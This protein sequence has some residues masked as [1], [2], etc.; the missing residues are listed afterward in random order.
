V[1]EPT[2]WDRVDERVLRWVATLPPSLAME[3]HLF[4]VARPEPFEPIPGLTSRD[5]H[6]SLRR[7]VSAGL[8]DGSEGPPLQ[9]VD[10]SKL[11]VTASG[12]IVLG[13]WPD[14]DRVATATS[15]HR[16]LRALAEDAPE[17]ERS[18]LVRAAGVVSRT[19]DEIVR[20]A[21]ADIAGTIVR[22]AVDP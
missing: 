1:A 21:A 17:E 22:E 15:L 19:A 11:R 3:I 2:L 10:W 20:G 12:W 13:E 18:A 14:L 7:L 6:A 4:E 8:V 16:L 9:S 5:V